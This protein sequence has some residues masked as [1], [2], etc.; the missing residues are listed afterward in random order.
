MQITGKVLHFKNYAKSYNNNLII[1]VPDLELPH[2]IYWLKGENGT[3]KTTLIKSIAGLIPFNG[4][5]E[6]G[7]TDINKQRI[8]YRQ[9]VNYA[10]AEPV[11][12]VFLTGNDLINFYQSTKKASDEQVAM[13]IDSLGIRSYADNKIGTYS[14][15]MT[16]KLS[17]VLGLMGRPKLVLLDEPL[18]T[19]DQ[20]SVANLQHIIAAYFHDGV[21][22]LITSHQEI[23]FPGN[24]SARLVLQDK[25]I[26]PQQLTTATF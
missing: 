15:G 11:Y 8:E 22:F 20:Q 14:S 5:I 13:L 3:G 1:Q 7:G 12:P 23:S 24:T 17:L 18:I 19:L 16:K 2:N 25:T 26:V 21:S 10:E 6:V 4:T 9:A